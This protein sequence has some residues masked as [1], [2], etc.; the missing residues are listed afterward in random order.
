M[1]QIAS[2]QASESFALVFSCQPLS[3]LPPCCF[4]RLCCVS[5]SSQPVASKASSSS[6]NNN[7]LR[8]ASPTAASE[9]KNLQAIGPQNIA[10]RLCG[11]LASA[12]AL[13]TQRPT[14]TDWAAAFLLALRALCSSRNFGRRFDYCVCRTLC[15]AGKHTIFAALSLS[16]SV[17]CLV[18]WQRQ[19]QRNDVAPSACRAKIPTHCIEL[20]RSAVHN[21]WLNHLLSLVKAYCALCPNPGRRRLFACP[22]LARSLNGAFRVADNAEHKLHCDDGAAAAAALGSATAIATNAD[23]IDFSLCQ[24]EHKVQD[25]HL[26]SFVAKA[27]TH[28]HSQSEIKNFLSLDVNKH[29]KWM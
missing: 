23:A 28:T 1:R 6:H 24:I 10:C 25:R 13:A 17:C 5:V 21:H 4:C 22:R 26:L 20:H 14:A 15:A 12:A 27:N 3:L 29:E 9:W 7:L 8:F 2:E 16:P 11:R 18:E 19:W